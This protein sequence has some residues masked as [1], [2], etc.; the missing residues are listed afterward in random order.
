[1]T[2][3]IQEILK[4]MISFWLY[5]TQQQRDPLKCMAQLSGHRFSITFPNKPK[6]SQNFAFFDEVLDWVEVDAPCRPVKFFHTKLRKKNNF[7]MDLSKQKR[8][9]PKL[10]CHK[11]GSKHHCML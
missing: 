5:V 10:S 6:Y 11:G 9:T 7:F 8:A 1:M 3:K 4:N 2:S